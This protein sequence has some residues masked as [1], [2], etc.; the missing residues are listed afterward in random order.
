[1]TDV[2]IL[3]HIVKYKL[4]SSIQGSPT[5]HRSQLQ[6][7]LTMVEEFG[8]LH[9]LRLFIVDEITSTKW[10]EFNDMEYFVK[11]IHKNM[12]WKDCPV[13]C[14]TL[15]HYCVNMFMHQHILKDIVI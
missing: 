7:L 1:M 12:S 9:F 8:M 13:E 3:G 11:Q 4:P 14:V 5:W 2:E 10:P 6:D 15:F